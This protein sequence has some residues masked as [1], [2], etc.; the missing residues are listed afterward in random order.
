MKMIKSLD[1]SPYDPR[2]RDWRDRARVMFE[3]NWAEAV[4]RGIAMDGIA[5]SALYA[6]CLAKL[7]ASGGIH[8]S[9]RVLP[10]DPRVEALLGEI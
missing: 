4:N 3:R 2:L 5:A 7:F 9:Q 8:V 10:E 1:I 6:R